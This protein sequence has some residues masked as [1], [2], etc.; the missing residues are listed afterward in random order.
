MVPRTCIDVPET[1]PRKVLTL[2][3]IS[4]EGQVLLGL[5]KRGFGEGLWNG[6]G[7]KVNPGE[8]IV[9]AAVREVEEECGLVVEEKDME[10]IAVIYFEFVGDP[11]IL[12]V[13]VFQTTK[14]SGEVKESEEM[15]PKWYSRD[16]VPHSQMWPDDEI[17]Y[18]LY[19]NG[20]K[21]QAYFLFQGYKTILSYV[22]RDYE[23]PN[24]ILQE[25]KMESKVSV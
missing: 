4:K 9:T 24:V 25:M 21:F 13:H 17:W 11:V 5:K 3:F 7:G 15:L 20:I 22:I 19:L 18:P 10:Q 8:K 16:N 2:A 23:D 6:F 14:F 1:A 12:E